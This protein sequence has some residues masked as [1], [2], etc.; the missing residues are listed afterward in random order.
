LPDIQFPSDD[1]TQ[2]ITA[3]IGLNDSGECVL[4]E[5][6]KRDFNFETGATPTPTTD[7]QRKNQ[8][9]A[10]NTPATPETTKPARDDSKFTI[11]KAH[12]F[13]RCWFAMMREGAVTNEVYEYRRGVC[14]GVEGLNPPCPFNKGKENGEHY[15]DKCGCGERKFALLYID[16]EPPGNTERLHMPDPQCP[17]YAMRRMPGSGSLK[18]V[19]GRI[20]QLKK[21]LVAAKEEV[22]SKG[23]TE[24]NTNEYLAEIKG[25]TDGTS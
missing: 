1:G 12:K 16:G 6:S 21:L 2:L 18:S 15:C 9:T 4:T 25:A 5:C 10:A 14:E 20:K 13:I 17:M 3:N 22:V 11:K 24:K 19:G 23:V 8:G 7:T